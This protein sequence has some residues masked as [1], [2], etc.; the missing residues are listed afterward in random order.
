MSTD[1]NEI[2]HKQD[3]QFENSD[4]DSQCSL[5]LLILQ[6]TLKQ[7]I[8]NSKKLN[9]QCCQQK[10]NKYTDCN[11][12]K[13]QNQILGERKWAAMLFRRNE[14]QSVMNNEVNLLEWTVK[15]CNWNEQNYRHIETMKTEH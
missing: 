13:R 11:N 9:Q 6:S 4:S 14:Q 5:Q 10:W 3:P 7:L 8:G 15:L 12:A 1:V 2:K